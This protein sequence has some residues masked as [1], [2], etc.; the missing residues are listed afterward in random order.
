MRLIGTPAGRHMR[1]WR[2]QRLGSACA[3]GVCV[4]RG[5]HLAIWVS[6]S[7]LRSSLTMKM[8]SKR[9]R[10]VVCS[11]MFSPADLRSSYLRERYNHC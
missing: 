1:V 7:A 4:V 6:R 3:G 8:R 10:M 9:D 5:A 2:W 11:S